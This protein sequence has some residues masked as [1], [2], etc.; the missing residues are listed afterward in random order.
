MN[1]CSYREISVHTAG[2]KIIRFSWQVVP[3]DTMKAFGRE[4][5]E[6][7]KFLASALQSHNQAALHQDQKLALSTK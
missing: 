2:H 7:H 1:Q 4:E 6:L 3:V 5:V